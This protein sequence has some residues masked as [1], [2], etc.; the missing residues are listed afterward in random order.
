[1][2]DPVDKMMKILPL[3]NLLMKLEMLTQVIH[4]MLSDDGCWWRI[5]R[6]VTYLACFKT[7]R[8]RLPPR[9]E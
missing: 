7:W 8:Q 4:T 2:T 5:S 9:S 1:M 6:R 3:K